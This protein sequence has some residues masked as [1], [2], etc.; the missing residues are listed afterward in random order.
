MIAD[1]AEVP[2]AEMRYGTF[3]VH[4][5]KFNQLIQYLEKVNK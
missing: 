1:Y 4:N 2:K 5:K 3:P